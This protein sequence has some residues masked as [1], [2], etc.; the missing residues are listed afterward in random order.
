MAKIFKN[1]EIIII[2]GL[3]IVFGGTLVLTPEVL[4]KYDTFEVLRRFANPL[5]LGVV[6]VIAGVFKLLTLYSNSRVLKVGSVSIIVSLWLVAGATFQLSHNP[7]TAHLFCY[8]NALIALGTL[9]SEV[10]E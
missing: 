2:S 3:T 1:W 9:L 7:T 6:F 5:S 8:S 10:V 4:L